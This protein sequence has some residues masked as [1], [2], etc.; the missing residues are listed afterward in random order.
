MKSQT[1]TLHN[2]FDRRKK[3][4]KAVK[5]VLLIIRPEQKPKIVRPLKMPSTICKKKERL[6]AQPL[7]SQ[8]IKSKLAT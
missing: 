7:G 5:K 4:Q 8:V 2:H 1:L 3:K 6:Q